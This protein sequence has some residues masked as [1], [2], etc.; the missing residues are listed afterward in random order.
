MTKNECR[1]AKEAQN[2]NDQE[3]E[4]AA[5]RHLI[6]RHSSELRHLDSSSSDE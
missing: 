5:F 6:I 2:L 4:I 3:K 1:M